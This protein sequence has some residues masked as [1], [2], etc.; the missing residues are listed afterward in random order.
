M[1]SYFLRFTFM[2]LMAVGLL[3]PAWA[4]FE[5]EITQGV[6]NPTRIAAVNFGWQGAGLLPENIAQI[7]SADLSRSGQ[8]VALDQRNMMSLPTR[9]D[10]VYYRDWRILNQ[11]FLLIGQVTPHATGGYRVHYELYD[12]Y[13]QQR[14]VEG[15][16]KAGPNEL[17]DAAH[18]ISDRIY[19]RLTGIKGAFSTRIAYVTVDRPANGAERV[20]L[21]VADA[22]GYREKI[23][24]E[25]REPIMSPHWSP[26]GNKLAYVSFEGR[27]PAVYIQ[28]V[29]TGKRQK[30]PAFRGINS[31]PAWSPDGRKLAMTLSKDGNPEIYIYEIATGKF[32]RVTRHFGID[33][34][35][36]WS[37]DGKSL[38]FTSSRGGKPQI[39][40]K[41]I[42]TGRLE[43][44]TF[45][46][47]YNARGRLSADGRYLVM[48][49]RQAGVFHIAVQDLKRDRLRVLTQTQLDESPSIAPN[50]SMIIYAT[51]DDNKGILAFVSLD[52]RVKSRG[53]SKFG[54]VR[55]PAWSPR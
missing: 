1:T 42:Q 43:R 16:I 14:M 21:L 34:E 25:S 10:Q 15:N 48:V 20:R 29:S 18:L 50:G 45:E 23:I 30:V 51:N 31:A 47:D 22:D 19:E 3:R 5:I 13:K 7:V 8:F 54:D 37:A 53:P 6:D 9:A 27:R 32:Q 24:R 4:S 36:S 17:R 39:Y 49:H 52:G 38:I 12:V 11:E 46:G 33:T 2:L 55:E 41:E 40:R 35:P 26:D 44:L 28:D